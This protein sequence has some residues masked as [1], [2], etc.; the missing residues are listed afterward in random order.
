MDDS[1]YHSRS[2]PSHSCAVFIVRVFFSG[3]APLYAVDIVVIV[4]VIN[5]LAAA[6]FVSRVRLLLA[7]F[8]KPLPFSGEK[9]KIQHEITMHNF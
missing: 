9:S 6:G 5:C 4:V 3:N 8:G 1:D 2:A 7:F